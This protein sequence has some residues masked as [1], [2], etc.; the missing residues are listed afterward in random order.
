MIMDCWPATSSPH[1][2][3]SS[4]ISAH[5]RRDSSRANAAHFPNITR[6]RSGISRHVEH[7]VLQPRNRQY[8][9]KTHGETSQPMKKRSLSESSGSMRCR[10]KSMSWRGNRYARTSSRDAEPREIHRSVEGALFSP[11][12][13]PEVRVALPFPLVDDPLHGVVVVDPGHAHVV[14]HGRAHLCGGDLQEPSEA[15]RGL[16]VEPHEHGH[17]VHRFRD[18]AAWTLS[19]GV[20]S[21]PSVS[22]L[23]PPSPGSSPPV[24]SWAPSCP[25]PRRSG[26]SARTGPSAFRSPAAPP[27][28]SSG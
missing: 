1:H 13:A 18:N 19:F 22:P 2:N 9:S 25:T 17:P 7:G 21:A 20:M 24:C 5:A 12:H 6:E 15:R 28:V 3:Q 4:G 26:R 16:G 10:R 14:S 27:P 8:I 11:L 23:P